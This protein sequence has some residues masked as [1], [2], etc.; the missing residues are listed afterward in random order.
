MKGEDGG[1]GGRCFVFG[2]PSGVQGPG[3][4]ADKGVPIRRRCVFGSAARFSSLTAFLAC[5]GC[6]PFPP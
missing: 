6:P 1:M 5:R 2:G 4:A 3:G